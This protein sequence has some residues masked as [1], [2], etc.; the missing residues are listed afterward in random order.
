VEE[1]HELVLALVRGL[2]DD[3]DAI[4]V[5]DRRAGSAGWIEIEIHVAP[6][7]RGRI[8]GRRGQTIEALRRVVQEG[9]R[10]RGLR[11]RLEV[12]S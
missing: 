8:I 2:V 4:R 1:L 9:A 12:A 5:S 7:D 6:A 3:Q 11:C 10:R